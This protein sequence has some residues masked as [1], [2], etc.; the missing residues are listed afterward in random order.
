MELSTKTCGGGG[1]GEQGDHSERPSGEGA[2][3]REGGDRVERW[4]ISPCGFQVMSV[5]QKRTEGPWLLSPRPF[6]RK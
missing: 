1:G 3:E 5:R 4:M 2:E 6:T